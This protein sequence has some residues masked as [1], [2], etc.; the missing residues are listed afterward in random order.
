MTSTWAEFCLAFRF[1]GSLRLI[2]VLK[3]SMRDWQRMLDWLRNSG[4]RVD[5]F[6]NDTEPAE[7][8]REASQ[9][10]PEPGQ[11]DR[12]LWV[13]FS[14]ARADCFFTSSQNIRL[15][16][17]PRE[18]K[19]PEE[20]NALLAFMRGLAGAV[21][22]AVLFTEETYQDPELHTEAVIFQ[23]RPGSPHLERP[24]WTCPW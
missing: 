11:C 20:W 16:I 3:T 23:V 18:I 5:Y 21:G 22:K 12:R 1:D 8:P 13:T 17:D 7:L 15:V 2:H 9:A 24:T 19:G 14:G 4:Y 10:F 6:R